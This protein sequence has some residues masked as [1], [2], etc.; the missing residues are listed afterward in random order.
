VSVQR[1][2]LM[3]WVKRAIA[4]MLIWRYPT[5][6]ERDDQRHNP[7]IVHNPNVHPKMDVPLLS[8]Y[9]IYF[10]DFSSISYSPKVLCMI[11]MEDS[12]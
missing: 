7:G 10:I 2:P 3:E 11:P 12:Q 6:S 4:Q 8:A 1:I 5:H 9:T